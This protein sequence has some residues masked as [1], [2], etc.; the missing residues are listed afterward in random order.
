M[1][2]IDSCNHDIFVICLLEQNFFLK[3]RN[4]ST[5]DKR[6]KSFYEVQL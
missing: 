1:R 6:K 4:N 3:E 5:K 2:W